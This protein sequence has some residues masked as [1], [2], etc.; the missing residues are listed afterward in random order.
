MPMGKKTA[1]PTADPVMEKLQMI[2]AQLV[3]DSVVQRRIREDSVLRNRWN[4]PAI[5]R[6]IGARP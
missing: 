6:T 2:V 4:D 5:K 3:Q 1:Q